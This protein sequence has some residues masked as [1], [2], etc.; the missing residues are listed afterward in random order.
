MSLLR[1]Q[2]SSR[3]LPLNGSKS[4][5]GNLDM[6]NNKILKIENLTDHKDDDPYED[7]VKDL[8][9]AV[10]KEY[11]N[12][13]FLKVDKDGNDFNLKQKTIKNGEPYYDGLFSDNYLVSKAFVDAEI[14]KLPKPETDVLKLDGSKAMTGNLDMGNKGIVNVNKITSE[15]NIICRGN[16]T[17]NNNVLVVKSISV[18]DD[19]KSLHGT[20]EGK[21]LSSRGVVFVSLRV[22]VPSPRVKTGGRERLRKPDTN[23]VM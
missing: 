19:I 13:K 7:I 8:K 15:D 17:V 16:L 18:N 4:M 3:L 2:I 10:N 9:S 11:L 21:N 6:D 5:A 22:A 14:G 20:V 1:S 23:R 12:E